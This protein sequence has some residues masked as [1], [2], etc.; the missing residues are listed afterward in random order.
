M[1]ENEVAEDMKQMCDT[2][3]GKY[4]ADCEEITSSVM[5]ALALPE[6]LKKKEGATVGGSVEE[7]ACTTGAR[8]DALAATGRQSG[9]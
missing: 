8:E 5:G 9:N 4:P 1:T 7:H 6:P 3:D 2:M